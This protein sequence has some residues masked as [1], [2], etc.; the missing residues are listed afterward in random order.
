M[1]TDPQND[2][3]VDKV[4]DGIVFIRYHLK[5]KEPQPRFPQTPFVNLNPLPDSWTSMRT[6]C[7]QRSEGEQ[8]CS[9]YGPPPGIFSGDRTITFH[10]PKIKGGNPKYPTHKEQ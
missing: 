4:F 8:E 7:V 3:I 6:C 1:R 9:V 10:K 2:L 5:G